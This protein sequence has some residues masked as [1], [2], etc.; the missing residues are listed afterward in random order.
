[1]TGD[2]CHYGRGDVQ[3]KG[4]V[5]IRKSKDRQRPTKGQTTIYKTVSRNQEKFEDINVGNQNP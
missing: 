3:L 1:M 5:R 4:V 2:R